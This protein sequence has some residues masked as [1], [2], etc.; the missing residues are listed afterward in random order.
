M[1][2]FAKLTGRHDEP[3][4]PPIFGQ[5]DELVARVQGERQKLETVLSL[6]KAEDTAVLPRALEKLEHRVAALTQQLDAASS[7][8]EQLERS[9]ATAN[10]LQARLTMLE[11]SVKSIEAVTEETVQRAEEIRGERAALQELVSAAQSTVTRLEAVA[12]DARIAHLAEHMPA[13][14]DDCARVIEQQGSLRAELGQLQTL[15]T[16]VRQDATTAGEVS[17]RANDGA[18]G[19]AERLASVERK[20]EAVSRFEA[21]TFDATGQLQTLNALAEHVALK[22]KALENQQ[23]TTERALV[24]S[25]RVGEM[26]W[27]MNIQIAKLGEGSTLAASVEETLGR[28]ERLNQETTIRLETAARERTQFAETVEQQRKGSAEL[29]Q[30]LQ[31]HL[32][33]LAFKKN[34]MDALQE[35]LMTAQAGLAHTEGRLEAL[36]ATGRILSDFGEKVD[37]LG[38]RVERVATQLGAIDEKQPFLDTL[39]K[40]LDEADREASRATGQLEGLSRRRQ[41]LAGV[42]AE[43]ATCEA[44]YAQARKLGDELRQE[45]E[46]LGQFFEQAREFTASAPAVATALDDLQSRVIETEAAAERALATRRG[47]EELAT[48]LDLLT[49]RLQVVD[50][51]QARLGRLHDLSAEIDQKLAAQLNRQA[52]VERARV[53]CDGLAT[54]VSD[55][56]HKLQTLEAAQSALAD[57]PNRIAALEADLAGARRSVASLQRDDPRL[58]H[59]NVASPSSVNRQA[60]SS[61]TSRRA[62]RR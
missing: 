59:R 28:L 26:V 12:G 32:E 7:R 2:F 17:K 5:V 35:R 56:Q 10:A 20:L 55:A 46:Q 1:D 38:S 6:V 15:A 36:S 30:N 4:L 33:R 47:I 13:L 43:L 37:S 48:R 54:Q 14:T 9:T 16:A 41:E 11:A 60:R 31:T 40:R 61:P 50:E 18:A 21:A 29:V 53:F 49:P 44:T 19:A 34:E 52:E 24:D 58:P 23:Q 3:A 45:K 25:R 51:V 8:A 42:T 62:S 39:E 27:E 22:V 57:V